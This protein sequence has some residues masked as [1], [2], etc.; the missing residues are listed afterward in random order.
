MLLLGYGYDVAAWLFLDETLQK[1][2]LNSSSN[3]S[4]S[5]EDSSD[6]QDTA[7]SGIE[8]L[9]PGSNS[10]DNSSDSQRDNHGIDFEGVEEDGETSD[11]FASDLDT[12]SDYDANS[13]TELLKKCRNRTESGSRLRNYKESCLQFFSLAR[14]V[15][16]VRQR[17]T[18]CIGGLMLCA[19]GIWEFNYSQC[20]PLSVKRMKW[21]SVA[22][23]VFRTFLLLRDRKV[24]LSLG[25]Y[26]VMAFLSIIINEVPISV[27]SCVSVT[28][29]TS[30]SHKNWDFFARLF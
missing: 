28:L 14:L 16:K 1:K 4:D 21:R 29:L 22:H 17:L 10:S 24:S 7:D 9:H 20:K 5:I 13:D 12:D 19:V 6:A 2:K 30:H 18:E 11:Q 3:D 15:R 8:L 25:L 26:G 27:V 23:G